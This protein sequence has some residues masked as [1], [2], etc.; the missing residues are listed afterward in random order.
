MRRKPGSPWCGANWIDVSGTRLAPRAR[1]DPRRSSRSLLSTRGAHVVIRNPSAARRAVCAASVRTAGAAALVAFV[2][3]GALLAR[4]RTRHRRDPTRQVRHRYGHD[5]RAVRVHRSGRLTSSASTWTCSVAIAKDQG[6]EVEIRQLGFDA[7]VQA[8][9]SNQV[10]AVMAGMSI[11]EERQKAFDFSEPYFTRWC[12]A[13]RV[14]KP[15]TSSRLDDLDGKTVAVKDRYAGADLRRREQGRV[16]LPGHSVPGHDRH[17]RCGQGRSGRSATSRT[18]PCWLTASSRGVRLPPHRSAGTGRRVRLAVNKG[19]HPT[20]RE[21]QRGTLEPEGVRRVRH[22]RRHV[23][24]RRREVH[25]AHRHHLGRGAVL[26][27]TH[28]GPLAHDPRDDRVRHRGRVHPGL[29]F[30][31]G[32]VSKFAPFRV[33]RHGLRFYVFRGT[34]ILIQAFFVFFAIRSCSPGLTFQ[35]VRRRLA[36]TLSLNTGAYMTEIIS[37][38]ASRPS[39]PDRTRPRARWVSDTGRRCRRSCSRRRSAS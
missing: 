11:T 33:D 35:P 16:R 25:A 30:G 19:Q 38:V 20:D 37:R 8:L 15:A 2:A 12:P 7:A 4:S 23:S 13:R 34:P 31:F 10:D 39:I 9:Q 26:A 14:S 22:D 18:S 6:F 1:V 29:V 27:R 24:L 17:G 28:G 21:V 32:R 3:V 5:V 36:I